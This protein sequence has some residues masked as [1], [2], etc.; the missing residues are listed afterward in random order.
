MGRQH[1][2]HDPAL[3]WPANGL[4]VPAEVRGAPQGHLSGGS[5]R[6]TVGYG[7]PSKVS[8]I[9]RDA[10]GQPLA[11]QD[12][13]VTEYFGDGALIDTRGAHREDRL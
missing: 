13:T 1:D 7:R 9:L 4:D 5:H 11:D 2:G 10:S 3:E 12:V 8:G 6:L